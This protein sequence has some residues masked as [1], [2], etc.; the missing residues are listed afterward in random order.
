MQEALHHS[1]ADLGFAWVTEVANMWE[2]LADQEV[3]GMARRRPDRMD[4]YDRSMGLS[5]DHMS[6]QILTVC[7]KA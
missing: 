1:L 4:L 3:I 2:D 6:R 5:Q 7:S